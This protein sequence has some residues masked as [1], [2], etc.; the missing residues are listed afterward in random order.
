MYFTNT[1]FP[2][3]LVAAP[4]FALP[5]DESSNDLVARA[6]KYTCK[7]ENNESD[8]KSF[9]VSEKR[10]EEQVKVAMF[11]AGT[12]GDPHQYGNGDGIKWGV[13]GCDKKGDKKNQLYE[14]PIFW[15]T[16]KMEWKKDELSKTQ[17][18]TP[19]RVVYFEDKGNSNRP[20]ICGVMTHSKVEK[21]FQGTAFFQKCK[22]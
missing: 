22:D 15:D 1:M 8:V 12:S 2:L 17:E 7:P 20:K 4:I 21:N 14:Y 3:A 16:A 6:D 5:F 11:T 10:A 9:A 19:L 13:K 18:K